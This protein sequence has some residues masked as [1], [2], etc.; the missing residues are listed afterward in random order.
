MTAFICLLGLG[1]LIY[2]YRLFA[3]LGGGGG[4]FSDG[5]S[6]W[7]LPT[8]HWAVPLAVLTGWLVK[9]TA[10][11]LLI[12]PLR[13]FCHE[14]GH[15]LIAWL[16]GC[17]SFP[18][19]SGHAIT[20]PDPSKIVSAM[21]AAGIV[22]IGWQGIRLRSALLLACAAPLA[23]GFVYFHFFAGPQRLLECILFAGH[24][25]EFVFPALLIAAFYAKGPSTWRWDWFRYPLMAAAAWQLAASWQFWTKAAVNPVMDIYGASIYSATVV[26]QDIAR[27]VNGMGWTPRLAADLYLLLGKAAWLS[28]L[29][30]YIAG[31]VKTWNEKNPAQTP[32]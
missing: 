28:V 18:S 3:Q 13:V 24:A 11:T 32:L 27:L 17:W 29:L 4:S 7:R 23:A 14:L 9:G 5:S 6:G 12:L 22:W 16:G 26:E 19:I 8:K 10:I 15:S 2:V 30:A 31:T 1:L 25:G 20:D 21:A